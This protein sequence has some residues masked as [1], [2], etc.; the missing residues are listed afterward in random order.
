MI[1]HQFQLSGDLKN[2]LKKGKML[3]N[4]TK[5][6]GNSISGNHQDN[7]LENDILNNHGLQVRKQTNKYFFII[8][9]TFDDKINLLQDDVLSVKSYGS[10]LNR[11]F[12]DESHK[13]SAETMEGEEKRDISK[14]DLGLDDGKY[15]FLNF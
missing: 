6:I 14:E 3:M 12:K 8:L 9:C 5:T 13:G 10:H 4:N 1:I 15:S 11:P 2:K 7:R